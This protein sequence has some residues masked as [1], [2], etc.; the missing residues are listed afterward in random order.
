MM[1]NKSFD[2]MLGVLSNSNG[3]TVTGIPMVNGTP[4]A[5]TCLPDPRQPFVATGAG[6]PTPTPYPCLPPYHVPFDATA[7]PTP[8]GPHY[9]AYLQ[10]DN[11]HQIQDAITNTTGVSP[12]LYYRPGDVP[13]PMTGFLA[14]AW[15]KCQ[16]SEPGWLDYYEHNPA[17]QPGPNGQPQS[18]PFDVMRYY[19]GTDLPNVFY[20]AQYYGVQD[21]LFEPINAYSLPSH[22]FLLSN[23]SATCAIS[24]DPS[25]CSNEPANPQAINN[26]PPL[27]PYPQA[28]PQ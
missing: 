27:T 28:W 4:A 20:Y 9:P 6:T 14:A 1:E 3:M 15:A 2:E 10:N 5:Y 21:H 7:T 17:C 13:T 18:A 12:S 26:Y 11:P 24:G 23:W 22:L 25:S 16:G 19:D 8:T